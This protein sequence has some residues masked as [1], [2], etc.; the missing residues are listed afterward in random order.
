[1]L[2]LQ[3]YSLQQIWGLAV[4][5]EDMLKGALGQYRENSGLQNTRKAAVMA[6]PLN[7]LCEEGNLIP[8][9]EANSET[10]MGLN[11]HQTCMAYGFPTSSTIFNII[12]YENVCYAP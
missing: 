1:M 9:F 5:G 8:S 6:A 7:P 12:I 11:L 10:E 4:S 3:K 2:A